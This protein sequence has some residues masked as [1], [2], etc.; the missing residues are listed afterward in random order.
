MD[1]NFEYPFGISDIQK[2]IAHRYPFLLVDRVDEYLKG[3]GLRATKNVSYTDPYIQGHFPDHPVMP[4]VLQVEALAQVAAIFGKLE[5]PRK[6]S[7]LLTEISEAR[8]RRQ[9]V[10]GDTLS[11]EVSCLKK[12]SSFFWFEAK[13]S[14]DG[15][16]ATSV[17]FSAKFGE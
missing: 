11:L 3:E 14:V 17:K 6:H 9:V 1:F 5:E 13:A 12:R 16:E 8:F 2:C 15:Q 4:G 7:V 10:P